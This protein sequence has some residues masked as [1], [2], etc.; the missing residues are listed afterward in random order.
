M[1]YSGGLYWSYNAKAWLGIFAHMRDGRALMRHE[2]A[3][4]RT[5]PELAAAE[6]KAFLKAKNIELAYVAANPELWPKKKQ[7]GQTVSETFQRAGVPMLKGSD[8]RINGWARI[9]SLLMVRD[10]PDLEKPS[11][12]VSSPGLIVHPDCA[13]FLRTFPTLISQTS[14]PDDVEETTDEY[15]ANGLRFWAMTRPMPESNPEPELPPGAIG[16]DIRKLRAEL[17]AAL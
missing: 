11:Q 6:L 1:T 5:P 4:I 13:F 14:N 2:L 3:W 17:E 7:S 16:H 10:W 12:K 8:D 9:R 15:P